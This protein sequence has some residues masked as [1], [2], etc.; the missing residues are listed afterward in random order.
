[1]VG[2]DAADG[3][4]RWSQDTPAAGSAETVESRSL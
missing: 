1:M 4:V 3:T 2:M